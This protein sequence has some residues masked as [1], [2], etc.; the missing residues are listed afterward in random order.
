MYVA[1]IGELSMLLYYFGILASVDRFASQ[2][3]SDLKNSLDQVNKAAA[4]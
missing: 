3:N 4:L 1:N 2:S